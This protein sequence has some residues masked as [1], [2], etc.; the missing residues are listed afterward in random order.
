MAI[1]TGL[2]KKVKYK[3]ESTWGTAAT[4]ASSTD[5]PR[6]QSSL[7]FRKATYESQNI[8]SDQQ[9]QDYRHGVQ[10]VQG[11][12][13][14]ELAPKT[15]SQFF[16]AILRGSWTAGTS[17]GNAEFTSITSNSGTSAFIVAASTWVAQG[18]KVGDIIRF[19]NLATAA[20]NSKN[21]RITALSGTTATVYPAPT[22]DAVAD[23]SFAVQLVGKKVFTPTTGHT[24]Q[25]FTF[26]HF[27]DDIDQSELFV[28]CKMAQMGINIPATGI[29]GVQLGVMGK[30][31]D[32]TTNSPNTAE[33]FTSPTADGN[34][35]ALT[36][37]N[38]AVTIN[39]TRY[40]SVTG[41][42]FSIDAG[43]SMGVT[44][45]TDSVAAIFPGILRV[46]G[47]FSAYFESATLRDLFS[48][49]TVVD[50]D[51]MLTTGTTDATDFVSFYLPRVKLGGN[52]KDDGVAGIVQSIPFMALIDTT[53]GS[54]TDTDAT[55]LVVQ[56]SQAP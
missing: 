32:T 1:A 19:T 42:N 33:Y 34:Y 20:N 23:T 12:I 40:T 50:L 43:M 13:S 4:S 29:A 46:S 54:G 26:E 48:N 21:F 28:G 52:D 37:V 45:G 10:S 51:F 27:H 18:F 41:A 44:V 39:G 22:T 17:K 36:A 14:G 6:I 24:D 38:G 2:Y 9:V 25:S 53:G 49:E 15:W 7:S 16:A 55:T 11:N 8:R 47:Q 35:G 30:K 56:D 3:V 31:L 5:L